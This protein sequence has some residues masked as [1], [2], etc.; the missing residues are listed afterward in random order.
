MSEIKN[1]TDDNFD[2]KDGGDI[3]SLMKLDS[4]GS[5]SAGS[6]DEKKRYHDEDGDDEEEYNKFSEEEENDDKGPLLIKDI[7]GDDEKE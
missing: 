5:G 3:D 4:D 6:G 1:L 7:D 2:S